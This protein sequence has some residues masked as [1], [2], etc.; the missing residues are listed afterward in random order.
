[1][2]EELLEFVCPRCRGGTAVVCPG[3]LRLAPR[4]CEYTATLAKLC[5][6]EQTGGIFK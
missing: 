2:R 3:E 1:M 4:G 5:L 6:L